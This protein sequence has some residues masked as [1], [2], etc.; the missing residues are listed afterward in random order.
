MFFCSNLTSNLTIKILLIVCVSPY[1]YTY[2]VFIYVL[3]C[4]YKLYFPCL[5]SYTA[6]IFL[7]MDVCYLTTEIILIGFGFVFY[8]YIRSCAVVTCTYLYVP[9]VLPLFSCIYCSLFLLFFVLC[10]F[11]NGN[12]PN[13]FC[14][15]FYMYMYLSDVS[16][17]TSFPDSCVC[18]Y[19]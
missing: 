4:W 3:T 6:V 7:L 15:C 12:S 13:Y 5:V 11:D 17:C 8:L 1:K 14:F 19:L 18:S 9:V 10:Y 2:L 16:T